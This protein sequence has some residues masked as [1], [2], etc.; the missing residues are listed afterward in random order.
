MV[1]NNCE[2]IFNIKDALIKNTKY[3]GINIPE[4]RC[5][6]CGGTFRIIDIPKELDHYLYV[7]DDNRYYEYPHKREN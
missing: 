4:K 6:R 2:H 7:N 1:C 5:P 3:Y